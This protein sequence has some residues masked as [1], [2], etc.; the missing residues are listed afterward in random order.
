MKTIADSTC[1]THYKIIGLTSL[2]NFHL[3]K[4]VNKNKSDNFLHWSI[5]RSQFIAI[6]AILGPHTK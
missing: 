2:E 1:K 6:L 5:A 4:K 3:K